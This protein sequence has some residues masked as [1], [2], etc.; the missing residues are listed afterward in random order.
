MCNVAPEALTAT[1]RWCKPENTHRYQIHTTLDQEVHNA[2][3]TFD[4]SHR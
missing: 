2:T 4:L 1:H 3:H